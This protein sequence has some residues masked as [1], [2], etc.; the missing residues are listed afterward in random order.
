MSKEEKSEPKKHQ[1]VWFDDE[2]L[3]IDF[4][5]NGEPHR[6]ELTAG[7][8]FEL[9]EFEGEVWDNKLIEAMHEFAEQQQNPLSDAIECEKTQTKHGTMVLR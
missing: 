1:L 3:R 4:I 2:Q 8:L 6:V 7:Q 5:I 9:F